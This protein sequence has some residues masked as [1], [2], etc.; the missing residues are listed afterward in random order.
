MTRIDM[1]S[2]EKLKIDAWSLYSV[3]EACV[4]INVG[5]SLS[6]KD[7]RSLR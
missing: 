2:E 5:E 6:D 7:D 4:M 3:D 1:Q